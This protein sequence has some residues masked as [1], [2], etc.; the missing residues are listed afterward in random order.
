M[1]GPF[2]YQIAG[3]HQPRCNYSPMQRARK[4]MARFLVLIGFMAR[5][6]ALLRPLILCCLRHNNFFKARHVPGLQNSRADFIS[7]FQIDSFKAISP[8]ADQF[9]T[10][11]PTNLLP[12]S[13]SLI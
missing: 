2:S 12:E 4:V 10:P 3:K 9:P 6:L 11:V 8:D 13:W 7:R 1:V 5:G